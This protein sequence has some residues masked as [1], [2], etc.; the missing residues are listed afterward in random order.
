MI[1]TLSSY[2]HAKPQFFTTFMN[3]VCTWSVKGLIKGN[4]R[5]IILSYYLWAVYN[6]LIIS[7]FPF[8]FELSNLV[9]LKLGF[10]SIIKHKIKY[11]ILVSSTFHWCN[12]LYFIGVYYCEGYSFI[13][14]FLR[15]DVIEFEN[16]I[17]FPSLWYSVSIKIGA[18]IQCYQAINI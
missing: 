10:W 11:L 18:P 9:V 12:A 16:L 4:F 17:I 2:N 13:K 15:L 3:N 1:F 14:F 8:I 6:I 7:E 5:G